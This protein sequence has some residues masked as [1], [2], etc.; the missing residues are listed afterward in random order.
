MAKIKLSDAPGCIGSSI[1]RKEGHP[2]CNNCPFTNVCAKL[3]RLNADRLMKD[4]GITAISEQTG[5]MLSEGA[6]K[7]TIAEL[8]SPRFK[9]KKPLTN[10]GAALQSQML[11]KSGGTMGILQALE[12][13]KRSL[14]D[15]ALQ[16]VQPDWARELLLLI[17]DNNGFV[18]KKDLRDY[19][20]HEL[21]MSRTASVSYVASF[22]N[23]TTNAD[24]LNEDKETLRLNNV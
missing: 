5:K 7:M 17:W 24:I 18:Q 21:G 12:S 3:A 16:N 4:L 1:I 19:A 2:I 8:E 10:R 14:V 15:H 20:Q 9:G 6:S 13:K 22:I 23:A 11:R